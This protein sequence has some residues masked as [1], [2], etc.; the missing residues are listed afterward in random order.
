MIRRPPRS[1]LFPYTTLFRSVEDIAHHAVTAGGAAGLDRAC[2]GEA[3]DL[4]DLVLA[5]V[6]LDLGAQAVAEAPA[7]ADHADPAHV[8]ADLTARGDSG[9]GQ[10]LGELAGGGEIG[11]LQP[12]HAGAGTDVEALHRLRRG[13]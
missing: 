2:A 4:V 5:V 7:Q 8:E 12:V 13:R 3:A 1:T 6:A 10:R 9:R 11:V